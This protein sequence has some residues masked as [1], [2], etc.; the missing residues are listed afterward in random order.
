MTPSSL[1]HDRAGHRAD[2]DQP[3]ITKKAKVWTEN[4]IY[5]STCLI[6]LTGPNPPANVRSNVVT[7]AIGAAQ[8]GGC[9][10]T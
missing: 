6:P 7:R 8:D 9:R 4:A 2:S 5:T 1:C 3:I 10:G